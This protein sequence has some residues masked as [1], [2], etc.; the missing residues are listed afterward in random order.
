MDVK[1]ELLD[2]ISKRFIELQR[3][4]IDRT[5]ILLRGRQAE[6]LNILPVLF[7][8]NHAALPGFSGQDTPNGIFHYNPTDETLK[9]VKK[10]WPNFEIQRKAQ[11]SAD[12]EA[13]FVMGSAGTIAFNRHSDFDIW[14]CFQPGMDKEQLQKLQLKASAIEEWANTIQLEV[15]FF[16]MDAQAFRQG[17]VLAMSAESSGTTQHRL[18][19]DEFYRTSIWLA[20]KHPMWWYIA[21][22]EE[23]NYVKIKKELYN[24]KLLSDSEVIDF[25]GLPS[26]PVEEFLGA[27]VWQVY[28]G[29]DSPHK[30]VLKITLMES[31]ADEYPHAIPLATIFK[32]AVYEELDDD[33][34]TDSYLLLLDHLEHYLM[35]KGETLRL[36]LIRRSFYNKL[37][38]ALSVPSRSTWRHE[39]LRQMVQVWGWSEKDLEL[40]DDKRQWTILEVFDERKLLVEHLTRSYLFLSEFAK[41]HS[42]KQLVDPKELTILGRKLYTIFEK[43]PGK[44]EIV[45]RGIS[46]DIQESKVTYL[47]AYDKQKQDVWLMYREKVTPSDMRNFSAIKV[48]PGL[49][50]LLAWGF[51]NRIVGPATQ[52]LVH[53][54]GS[55]LSNQDISSLMEQVYRVCADPSSLRPSSKQLKRTTILQASTLFINVGSRLPTVSAAKDKAIVSGNVDVLSIDGKLAS[56]VCA[57]EFLYITTWQEVYV[58]T[59]RQAKGLLDWCADFLTWTYL[60]YRISP[61]TLPVIPEVKCYASHFSKIICARV[62]T[63]IKS[64]RDC[65]FSEQGDLN[66]RYIMEVGKQFF[67]FK[68]HKDSINIIKVENFV[69][70]LKELEA[71]CLRYRPL[72]LDKEAL[73]NSIYAEVINHNRKNIVQM[74]YQVMDRGILVV[75]IDD[76]GVMFQQLIPSRERSLVIQQYYEFLRAAIIQLKFPNEKRSEAMTRFTKQEQALLEV[77]EV[78]KDNLN[79]QV[80][81]QELLG[82]RTISELQRIQAKLSLANKKRIFE[83]VCD[84]QKLSSEQYGSKVFQQ[85]RQDLSVKANASSYLFVNEVWANA[86]VV[87]L[88]SNAHLQLIY[89][90]K[91]KRQLENLINQSK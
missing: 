21:P 69:A 31:Y 16:L 33:V 44:V 34:T 15:H 22:E 84:K 62:L 76:L 61:S 73:Q 46:H 12:I 85:V 36:E 4:R 23:H 14:L 82:L 68:K 42:D 78:R 1:A 19:L 64:L 17:K 32:K 48:A 35:A 66:T 52:A 71:P 86:D 50:E 53:A 79:V 10:A 77:Y 83:F 87:G 54:P 58:K 59:Y 55:D 40:L 5:A 24:E 7:H 6:F 13:L 74:F 67:I 25:G 11:W 75:V 39:K 81:L 57:T 91:Y 65:Y 56:L 80:T 60:A 45:N 37:E 29:I 38:V 41:Q 89:F 20:G 9:L 8:Y 43:K 47:Q 49:V 30:S 26:I 51:F 72:V 90:L 70:L 28:K 18:L 88:K 27:A 63:L 2:Q 3:R